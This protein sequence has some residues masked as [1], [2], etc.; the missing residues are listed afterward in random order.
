MRTFIRTAFI[1]TFLMVIFSAV[2]KILHV[3]NADTY[4][5]VSLI[6]SYLSLGY[7]IYSIFSSK[8]MQT[9]S[10]ALWLISIYMLGWPIMLIYV[11]VADR[12][13]K[14]NQDLRTTSD[15]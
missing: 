5:L 12:K 4:L 13:W 2:A 15:F 1:I 11:F 6:P 10:K 3:Q 9:S 8:K 7:V 14:A